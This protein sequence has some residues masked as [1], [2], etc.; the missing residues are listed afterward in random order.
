VCRKAA[1]DLRIE[2]AKAESVYNDHIATLKPSIDSL[3]AI[4]LA[5]RKNYTGLEL[6]KFD[7][8][9]AAVD[10]LVQ[11]DWLLQADTKAQQ[12]VGMLPQFNFDSDRSKE[13]IGRVPGEWVCTNKSKSTEDKAVNAVEKK[14]FTF[15]KDGSAKFIES[16]KGQSGPYLKEDWEFVSTGSWDINGDTVHLFTK[17]FAA[18]RQNAERLF[19]ENHG[20][21]KT[22]KKEPPGAT[23]DSLITDGSQDRTVTFTDLKE[24]FEQTKK[25]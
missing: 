20:K 9:M 18:V 16:K 13:L 24:D 6:K 7:S 17:R 2:L 10:S 1:K 25:F 3:K 21:T 11:I 23:Y 8:L 12:M 4:L 14:I 5:A 15:N 19:I 22:W